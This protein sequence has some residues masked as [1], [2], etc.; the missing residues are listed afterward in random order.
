MRLVTYVQNGRP[1]AGVLVDGG[2][3]VLSARELATEAGLSSREVDA[4]DGMTTLLEAGPGLQAGL[5]AVLHQPHAGAVPIGDVRLLPPIPRPEKILCLG[6]NYRDHALE[7]KL[8]A[9]TVPVVFPKY[10]NSLIGPQDEVILPAESQQI[11][12]EGELAVVIGT[13]CKG[14]SPEEALQYVAGVMVF[15]DI[16]ARDLQFETSQWTLGK[17]IDTF[18]PCG[19]AIVSLDEIADIQ[20]LQIE[21]RLN[22]NLVQSDTTA[23]MIFPVAET[24]ARLAQNMTLQPGDIIATGTPAG[25]GYTREPPLF[26]R[27][28]DVIEITI[29]HV[30]V[31]RNRVSLCAPEDALT[32]EALS[33]HSGRRQ[34]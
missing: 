26:L 19:P 32:P 10:A 7:T 5:R 3:R 15:N 11:D 9:P 22:G 23:A 18:A 25:V 17:A 21:T 4:C 31:L 6:L 29:E 14:V 1:C 20:A 8:A 28:N 33:L 30:G 13:R 24:V 34:S 16:T 12:Y 27:E 2:L